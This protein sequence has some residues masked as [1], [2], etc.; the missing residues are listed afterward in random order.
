LLTRNSDRNAVSLG[1]RI[2]RIPIA[3][4]ERAHYN[5]RISLQPGDEQYDRLAK[6]IEEFGLVEPLVYNEFNGRLVGGHQRL[7]ILEARGETDVDVSVVHIEDEARE[8]AL[9]IALNNVGG[10]WDTEKLRERLEELSA[11]DIDIEL[12]GWNDTEI[13]DLL[14]E[15][16]MPTSREPVGITVQDQFGII[17]ICDNEKHQEDVFTTLKGMGYNCRVVVV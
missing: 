12:T 4:I 11:A 14:K 15:A 17:V 2:M 7:T 1:V 16:E 3:Q 13:A 9:N 5:P 8:K 10:A 6:G